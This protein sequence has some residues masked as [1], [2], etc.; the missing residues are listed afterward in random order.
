MANP[1]FPIG[2]VTGSFQ[3]PEATTSSSSITYTDT[4]IGYLSGIDASGAG[5]KQLEDFYLHEDKALQELFPGFPLT[6]IRI[7]KDA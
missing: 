7:K 2:G 1:M 3:Q 4:G 5:E 6:D